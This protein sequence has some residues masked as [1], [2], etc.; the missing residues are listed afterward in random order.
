MRGVG[1]DGVRVR[2][3]PERP[4]GSSSGSSVGAAQEVIGLAD[5]PFR[6]ARSFLSTLG[7]LDDTLVR[8]A[9]LTG[10]EAWLA[11]QVE[12]AVAPFVDK[13]TPA[14]LA[15]MREMLTERLSTEKH[16]QTLVRQARP[17]GVEVSGEVAYGEKPDAE[18]VG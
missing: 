1:E 3:L 11:E 7:V 2:R 4:S 14:E 18:K 9:P 13:V 5:A 15:W 10:H 17:H 12:A 6:W 16:L 8:M